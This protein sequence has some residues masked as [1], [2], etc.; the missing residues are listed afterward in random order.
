MSETLAE[1]VARHAR[2]GVLR[3]LAEM[4]ASG[5]ASPADVEQVIRLALPLTTHPVAAS[6]PLRAH[7][8]AL[9]CLVSVFGLPSI[10]LEVAERTIGDL[11]R[12]SVAT[13]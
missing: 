12:E 6:E 3:L 4:R 5:C 11:L 1:R 7:A 13:V 10:P 8:V 9:R 2:P